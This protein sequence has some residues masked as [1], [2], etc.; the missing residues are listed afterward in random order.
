MHKF[1]SFFF[2]LLLGASLNLIAQDDE[3]DIS[4]EEVIV[5]ATSR[6]STVLDVPYN[7]STISVM[8]LRIDQFSIQMN[9]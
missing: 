8:K 4:V 3:A 7:I 5:T 9:F 2:V 6:E 1:I